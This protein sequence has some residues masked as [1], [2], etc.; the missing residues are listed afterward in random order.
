MPTSNEN[1][2]TRE[3]LQAIGLGIGRGFQSYDP[4]NPFAGAGAAMEATIGTEMNL[5]Q[6]R[7]ARTERI[8]D[9][10]AV[11][12][13]KL[14]AEN[15][16]EEASI[17][18]DERDLTKAKKMGDISTELLLDRQAKQVAYE[19]AEREKQEVLQVSLGLRSK[20]PNSREK[21][22]LR[23]FQLDFMRVVGGQVKKISGSPPIDPYESVSELEDRGL[24]RGKDYSMPE[25]KT[26]KP[27]RSNFSLYEGMENG[28]GY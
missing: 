10:N 24:Q 19:K 11:R 4:N 8:E 13:E 22:V 16:S 23:Q 9:F 21:E 6:Q 26:K 12:K 25:D 1:F 7:K 3:R 17:R 20:T 5:E 14:D 28:Y 18:Q 2:F 27:V 15:R